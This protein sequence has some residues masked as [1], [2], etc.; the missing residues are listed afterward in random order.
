VNMN[1]R[2]S[3]V[4]NS[5]LLPP[6]QS[7]I[8]IY[9]YGS[10]ALQ[11][12]CPWSPAL[13]RIFPS[14]FEFLKLSSFGTRDCTIAKPHLILHTEAYAL[15]H[16]LIEFEKHRE[17]I[18]LSFRA[19]FEIFAALAVGTPPSRRQTAQSAMFRT[20]RN[21]SILYRFCYVSKASFEI[22][23][24]SAVPLRIV[25]FLRSRSAG[26]E[27]P[28]CS[29][30]NSPL[31]LEQATIGS[32]YADSSMSVIPQFKFRVIALPL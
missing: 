24:D 11:I 1:K 8:S 32:S 13:F 21:L 17:T 12:N 23:Y 10:Q 4:Q 20:R 15:F 28:G 6:S 30:A 22:P 19:L 5:G 16:D 9:L 18:S 29:F 3:R 27:M 2:A 14:L 31:S 26:R 25:H 7:E